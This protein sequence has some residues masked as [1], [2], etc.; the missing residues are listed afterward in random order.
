MVAVVL[1]T[2][3]TPTAGQYF[4]FLRRHYCFSFTTP[5]FVAFF[6]SSHLII[7]LHFFILEFASGAAYFQSSPQ[8]GKWIQQDGS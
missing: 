2:T 3:P 4:L 6:N 1:N 8:A 7:V 5:V